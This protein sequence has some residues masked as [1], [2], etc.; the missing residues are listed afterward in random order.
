VL[1]WSIAKVNN[2]KAENVI[3]FESKTGP[4]FGG[5]K[6]NLLDNRNTYILVNYL[7]FLMLM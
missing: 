2:L 4:C 7:I 1:E 5:A 3:S 6:K